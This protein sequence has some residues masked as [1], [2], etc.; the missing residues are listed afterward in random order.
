MTVDISILVKTAIGA[1]AKCCFELA[2]LAGH[3]DL[4]LN[5]TSHGQ[6]SV[7]G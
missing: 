5:L 2:M 1:R 6:S 3:T 4:Q 7:H